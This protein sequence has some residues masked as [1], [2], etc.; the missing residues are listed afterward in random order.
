[1]YSGVLAQAVGAQAETGGAELVQDEAVA[2]RSRGM[3]VTEMLLVVENEGS[4]P[5]RPAGVG[6]GLEFWLK[7]P[8]RAE[9]GG[10]QARELALLARHKRALYARLERSAG[11]RGLRKALADT[12]LVAAVGVE[13]KEE[14]LHVLAECRAAPLKSARVREVSSRSLGLDATDEGC[15]CSW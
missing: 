8:V 6:R 15:I 3:G 1:V 2:T 12:T 5:W 11:V 7:E 9:R 14:G 4:Q 13:Q 10:G